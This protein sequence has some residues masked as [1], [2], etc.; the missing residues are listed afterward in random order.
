MT[1]TGGTMNAAPEVILAELSC[2]FIPA[3]G[4]VILD[5]VGD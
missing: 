5:F 3:D 4:V 1:R 2:Q